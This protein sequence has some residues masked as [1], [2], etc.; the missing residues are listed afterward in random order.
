MRLLW[1]TEPRPNG[2]L[3]LLRVSPDEIQKRGI[4]EWDGAWVKR[5][6]EKPQPDEAPSDIG[7]M[8]LYMFTPR[9]LDY[10]PLVPLSAR[11]EYEL[12]DAIQMLIENED[13]VRGLPINNRFTLTTAADLL[14]INRHYMAVGDGEPQL[15]PRRVGPNTRLITPLHIER[16]VVIGAGCTIG[17]NVYIECGSQ[18]GDNTHLQDAVVLRDAVIVPGSQVSSQVVS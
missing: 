11:G 10:L 1:E 4:V 17:P 8:P 15:A 13:R 7:S 16:E 5:I 3:S 12:Q 9:I 2:L 6:V 18:I 14:E